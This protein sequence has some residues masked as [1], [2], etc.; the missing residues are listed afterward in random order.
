MNKLV[1]SLASTALLAGFGAAHAAGPTALTAAAMDGI[2]AGGEQSSCDRNYSRRDSSR[3]YQKNSS[4]LSPQVNVAPQTNVSPNVSVVNIGYNHQ[5][6][7]NEQSASQS[8]FYGNI[9][10]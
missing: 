4:F 9:S 8:N 5:N 10:R 3:N 7:S 6:T 1:L 2:T